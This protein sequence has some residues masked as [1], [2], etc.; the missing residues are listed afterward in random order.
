MADLILEQDV[1]I[2][3]IGLNKDIKYGFFLGAG[4]SIS[5]GIPS[6]EACIWEW[7]R[8]I[9]LSNNTGLEPQFSELTLNTTHHKIQKWLDNQAN[10]PK[11]GD[12]SE[13]SFYIEKCY[14][15]NEDWR[16]FF[17]SKI[18]SAKSHVGY[19]LLCL[20]AEAK[21]TDT[22]FTTNFDTQ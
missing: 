7:K 18:R 10:Y 12:A 19:K 15:T 13:Y 11:L 22:I 8:S 14:D 1:F 9:F 16:K 5:S 20:L 3:K 17:D 4:A 2:R 21:L 6:A